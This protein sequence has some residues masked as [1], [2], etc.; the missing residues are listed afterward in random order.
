MNQRTT[1]NEQKIDFSKINRSE[2]ELKGITDLKLHCLRLMIH[3]RFIE[4]PE[5]LDIFLDRAHNAFTMCAKHLQ[6]ASL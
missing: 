1:I 6:P 2:K 3:A 4:K 5:D